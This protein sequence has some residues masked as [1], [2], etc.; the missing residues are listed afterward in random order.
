MTPTTSRIRL[1]DAV[2]QLLGPDLTEQV[3]AA[4]LVGG[5]CQDCQQPLAA[6]G[7]VNV[8]VFQ[9]QHDCVVGY[10]HPDCGT[11]QVRLLPAGTLATRTAATMPMQL[12]AVVHHHRG[13]T[14]PVLAIQPV[15]QVLTATP[16]DTAPA[17]AFVAA[18]VQ[19]GMTA[20]VDVQRPPAPLLSW[21]VAISPAG[22]GKARIQIR[23]PDGA[24]LV[25]GVTAIPAAWRDAASRHG[26][27]V[28]YA[29]HGLW[30]ADTAG[31]E[32]GGLSAGPGTVAAARLRL[33]GAARNLG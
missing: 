3:T 18:L 22:P 2:R 28:L 29:G 24:V 8:V 27:C 19:A 30:D 33:F 4:S 23:M 31:P 10:L 15:M 5:R 7:V 20:D 21:P 9:D 6:D 32:T 25:D 1:S 16:D 14:L 12:A 13:R 11:S 17:D 26:W